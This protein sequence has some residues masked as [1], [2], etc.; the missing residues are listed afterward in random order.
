MPIG[1]DCAFLFVHSPATLLDTP[2][3]PVQLFVNTNSYLANH[4]TATR[5]IEASRCGEDKL[6]KFQT[7][8]Q[9]G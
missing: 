2:I 7:K 6:L 8:Q 4:M 3:E 5:C 9:N 1:L